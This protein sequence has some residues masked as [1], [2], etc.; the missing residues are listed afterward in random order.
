MARRP[1][2]AVILAAGM[3]MRLSELFSEWPKGFVEIGGETLIDRSLRLL[4]EHGIQETWIVAGHLGHAYHDLAKDRPDVRVIDNPA[5]AETGSMASLAI[6]LE[7]VEEDFLLLESDLFYEGRALD[8]VLDG[9]APDVLLASGPTGATDEVWIEAPAGRLI[10]MSKDPSEL[11]SVDGELVGILRAS[12]E[13][14][15]GLGTAY[16]SFVERHGHGR[17]A[18]E[19]DALVETAQHRAVEV[20]VVPDLLWGEVDYAQHYLRVRDE[21]EPQCAALRADRKPGLGDAHG[22]QR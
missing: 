6:A 14:A 20:R 9:A 10:A 3:G 22:K 17:M 7:H 4:A 5:Y 1:G 18:Y 13:L 2:S 21:I 12:R 8:A 16:H 19:T 11:R 15:A